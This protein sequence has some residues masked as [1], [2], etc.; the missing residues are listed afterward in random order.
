MTTDADYIILSQFK[1]AGR[2]LFIHFC[3]FWAIISQSSSRSK[4]FPLNSTKARAVAH[5]R[6]PLDVSTAISFGHP[7]ITAYL[8][9]LHSASNSSVRSQAPEACWS[10]VNDKRNEPDDFVSVLEL[11][12]HRP[13]GRVAHFFASTVS[14]DAIIVNVSEC[15]KHNSHGSSE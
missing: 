7:V 12:S 14:L 11:P 10:D 3:P 6:F 9:T 15:A 4:N 1:A 2:F 8:L 13:A 5:K